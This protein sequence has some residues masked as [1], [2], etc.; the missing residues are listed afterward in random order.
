MYVAYPL[1]Q[2][3]SIGWNRYAIRPR[4]GRQRTRGSI[5]DKGK[6]F[7]PL[8]NV[9]TGSGANSASFSVGTG[10]GFPRS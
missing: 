7:S 2:F 9:Q 4:A 5:P 8:R 6:R 3:I 10:D 1:L